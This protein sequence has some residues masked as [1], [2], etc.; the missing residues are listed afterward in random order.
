MKQTVYMMLPPVGVLT[1]MLLLHP[2]RPA[3]L[4][5]VVIMILR[6]FHMHSLWF[7]GSYYCFITPPIQLFLFKQLFS[8]CLGIDFKIRTI[9]LEGKRVKLQIW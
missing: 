6:Q 3:E 4:S 5:L 9:E 7:I 1:T 2:H 8:V